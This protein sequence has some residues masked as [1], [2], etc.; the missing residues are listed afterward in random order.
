[1]TLNMSVVFTSGQKLTQ[2]RLKK[3]AYNSIKQADVTRLDT[4]VCRETEG[5]ILRIWRVFIETRKARK[6]S[7]C[8][9]DKGRDGK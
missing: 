5:K 6:K 9:R 3:G 7:F 8:Q 4:R 2:D 1:M